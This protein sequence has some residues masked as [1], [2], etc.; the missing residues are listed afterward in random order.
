MAR[1]H[2]NSPKK[3]RFIGCVLAGNT[4]EAAGKQYNIP[5]STASDI[6]RKFQQ[7]GSTHN[8][9]RSGR[10]AK[11]TSRTTH[12]VIREAK[13]H[14]HENLSAIGKMV[15]PSIS[16]SAVRK[17]LANEGLHRRK[18]RKV[19]FLAKIH[20]Q[21][22]KAWAVKLK[23][24][25]DKEW[26]CIIWSDKSYV[27]IGDDRGTVWVTRAADEEFQEDCVIPTFKQSPLRIMIWSC[28]MR[29]SRGPLV[30]LDYPGGKGGGMTAQ[31][32]QDQVLDRALFD[33]YWK[34]LESRGQVIFQQ[35]GARCHTAKSTMAWLATNLIEIFPH[36]AASPD[37]S[38]IEP[39]WN[40]LKTLIR[41]RSHIP[42][43]IEELK[44]AVR[45]CWEMISTEDIDAHVKHMEDRV[46]AVLAAN[47]GHTKY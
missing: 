10:P 21:K 7:T 32:Y 22:R 5:Q 1:I 15:T 12:A 31:R 11:I 4:V 35:D 39:L 8:R 6:W 14:R 27:Y 2:H 36:P 33:Y 13:K 43:S 47:G 37:L 26:N 34:M 40:R 45:E 16:A 23:N 46:K 42:S 17:I 9:P 19:V 20:K 3:N 29:G 18:A 30:I 41:A 25:G 28:I 44:T 38:P 24:W